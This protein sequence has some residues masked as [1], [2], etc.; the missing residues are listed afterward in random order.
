LIESRNKKCIV[1][2]G[3]DGK[4]EI[5]FG[6]GIIS[7]IPRGVVEIRYLS[8]LGSSGNIFNSQD[9]EVNFNGPEAITYNP[10]SISNENVSYYLNISPLGGDDIESIESIKNNAPRIFAS[11]DRFVNDDDYIAG[12]K[13]LGN[14]KY[15][16]AYGEDDLGIGDYRYSNVIVYTVLKNL[17]I[18]DVNS[19]N[20]V[21]STP[22]QYVFSGLKTIDILRKM[23][24][25]AG[26][27]TDELSSKFQL[28]YLNDE[29]DDIQKYNSYVENYGKIFRLSKQ[30]LEV[31][32]ELETIDTALN[33]K[34]QLTC[35]H[36][37]IPPKVHKFRMKV[38]VYASPIISKY[39]LKT[40]I[41]QE[42]YRYLR[43]NTK[44]NFPIYSSKII[45]QI[46]SKMGIVGCH[47]DFI[48]D[49]PIPNDSIFINNLVSDSSDIFYNDLI[50]TLAHI[51][52]NYYS[53]PINIKLFP[54]F[55]DNVSDY[56]NYLLSY[57]SKNSN[58]SVELSKMNERNISNFIE[59]IYR[60]TL[61][62]LILNPYV[63]GTPS[64]IPAVLLNSN[65]SNPTT[66][67]NIYDIFVRWAVQFR[68]DTNYYTAKALINSHGDIS[69][70]SIPHEIAQVIVGVDD[71]TVEGKV[72]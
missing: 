67:E 15:A 48:P 69:N 17:Y 70:F 18:N 20:L 45:K 11:L 33:K 49:D 10:S 38:V 41:Q 46:E 39:E 5:L 22:S 43:E 63:Y 31:G 35:R 36:L 9:V 19:S 68:R 65:F 50:A 62:K 24:D 2:T 23:Q 44:F 3:N 54:K 8:T 29:L 59:F 66:G 71:I 6:D 58:T 25:S 60:E 52:T 64:N 61:G 56:S 13:T 26:W 53:S 34:G 42:A 7:E 72:A 57:F 16:M 51:Q 12:L 30:N 27:P 47:V 1:R 55:V 40:K 21:P 37:Y 4:I 32:S 28:D 14:V